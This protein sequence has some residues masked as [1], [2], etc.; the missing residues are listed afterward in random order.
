LKRLVKG[1]LRK[2]GRTPTKKLLSG[3]LKEVAGNPKTR[4]AFREKI[5]I[6][7]G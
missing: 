1:R 5:E 2:K 4:S 3:T 6:Y 7:I